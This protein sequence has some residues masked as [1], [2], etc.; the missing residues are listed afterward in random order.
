MSAPGVAVRIC[1]ILL[2]LG[3]GFWL[4][5]QLLTAETSP[6]P[7]VAAPPPSVAAALR[8]P[9]PPAAAAVAPKADTPTRLPAPRAVEPERADPATTGENGALLLRQLELG[10]GP[11]I[12]IAWPGDGSIR[13][14][15][16]DRLARC[17]GMRLALMDDKGR[18]FAAEGEAGKPWRLNADR[19]SGFVRRPDRAP[20]AEDAAEAA[21][22]RARHGLGAAAIPVG[23]FP[24][25]V[26]AALLAGLARLAGGGYGTAKFIQA[27][28]RLTSA[29]V[30]IDG[31]RIDGR[32][33]PGG[34]E[35]P[36]PTA[37]RG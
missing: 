17:Y 25:L 8:L 36:A 33:A 35:L 34:I 30:G 3:V 4:L 2:S 18:L 16:H 14:Q 9:P 24:R 29:G 32:A 20:L 28:Y 15:V 7:L 37:C 31:I 10:Q 26:D 11:D 23:I 13:R 5:L 22:L 12:Q 21:R 19:Y 6:P 1:S 27:S